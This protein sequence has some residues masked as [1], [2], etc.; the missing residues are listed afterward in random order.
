[1]RVPKAR[2]PIQQEPVNPAVQIFQLFR[3]NSTLEI[4]ISQEDQSASIRGLF[5]CKDAVPYKSIQEARYHWAHLVDQGWQP[6]EAE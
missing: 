1:M 3:D 5:G 4:E 6:L 2:K